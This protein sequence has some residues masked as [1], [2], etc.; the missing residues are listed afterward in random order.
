MD[1][2]A[3]PPLAIKTAHICPQLG[4]STVWPLQNCP[5]VSAIHQDFVSQ[6][7]SQDAK[8]G[9]K[10]LLVDRMNGHSGTSGAGINRVY[11]YI[12]IHF[13]G[14]PYPHDPTS[15]FQ[16][17]QSSVQPLVSQVC[18]PCCRGKVPCES[19]Q[20]CQ[21]GAHWLCVQS[22]NFCQL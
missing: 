2:D 17:A 6:V 10:S 4:A 12:Y 14:A 19:V 7:R 11:I 21:P 1:R 16:S 5:G 13:C 15:N 20:Y 9:P 8:T 3:S 18:M 22:I